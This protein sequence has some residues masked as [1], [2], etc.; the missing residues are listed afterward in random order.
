MSESRV[1]S[2][3]ECSGEGERDIPVLAD[4]SREWILTQAFTRLQHRQID[5]AVILL[6]GGSV[7][8]PGDP[9]VWRML[10]YAL[11]LADKPE[12]SLAAADNYR[13]LASLSGQAKE[14]AWIEGRARLRLNR[15][16]Q[17]TGGDS[18]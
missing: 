6:R 9:D 18:Q 5:D 10:S 8:L 17:D 13:R 16:Q 4:G 14:V 1:D 2:A 7:F 15:M 11:L 3:S 12:E